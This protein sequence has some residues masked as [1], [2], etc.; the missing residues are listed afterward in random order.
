MAMSGMQAA[1]RVSPMTVL[2]RGY[3]ERWLSRPV[4]ARLEEEVD[5]SSY[6]RKITQQ[7]LLA[8]MLDAVVGMQ[9]SVHAAAVAR[10]DQWQGSLQALYTKLARVDPLFSSDLVRETAQEAG[11]FLE[12]LPVR[13]EWNGRVKI[14]DGTMPD[15]SENRLG[16][17][18]RLN[19]AGLPAQCVVVYDRASGIC[20]R[21]VVDEDAYAN[22]RTLAER[23][24]AEAEAGEIYVADRGF[25]TSRIIAQLLDLGASFVIRE[26]RPALIYHDQSVLRACGHC[27]T[28]AVS[29]GS[30]RLYDRFSDRAWTLRRIVLSLDEPTSGGE[31]EVRLLTN[32][33]KHKSALKVASLYRERWTVERHFHFIKREL[34]GQIPSLGQPRAAILALCL[35]FAA[36]NIL[37]VLKR[38]HHHHASPRSKSPP[39]LSGYYLALE[40]SRSYTAVETLTTNRDWQRIATLTTRE[41]KKWSLRLAGKIPWTRFLSHPRGPKHPPPSRG[42]REHRRHYSTQRLKQEQNNIADAC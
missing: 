23:L 3:L 5:A 4:L 35:A 33:P 36:G 26:H 30:V 38:L 12:S 20:Q 32:L 31:R 34:N 2:V 11:S 22:E 39:A 19:A 21:V 7:A 27:E 29:E 24:L 18:R 13:D 1:E 14:I 41:L 8:I 40:I 28:G 17:L 9:P 10:R 25:S 16:V 42:R 37:M 15:A 6:E